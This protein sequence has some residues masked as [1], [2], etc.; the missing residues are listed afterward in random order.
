M[1]FGVLQGHWNIST[2]AGPLPQYQVNSSTLYSQMRHRETHWAALGNALASTGKCT[3]QHC[4]AYC[5]AF[6]S[7]LCSA[8]QCALVSTGNL[9][10]HICTRTF[11][12]WAPGNALISTGN[13]LGSTAEHALVSTGNLIYMFTLCRK[14]LYLLMAWRHRGQHIYR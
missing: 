14:T 10:L 5:S 6:Q 8:K 2:R 9:I 1:F 12:H 4:T 11:Q 13:A 7:V 3:G